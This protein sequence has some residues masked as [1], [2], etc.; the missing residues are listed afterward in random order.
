MRRLA[1]FAFVLLA[2]PL[3]AACD[4]KQETAAPQPQEP[5]SE[6]MARYCDMPVLDHSGPKGQIFVAGE[7]SPI[8]FA[9]ARDMV[10]FT[11][12]PEEPKDIVAIY[13]NDMGKADWDKPGAGTWTDARKAWFVIDS[14]RQG[15]MGGAEVVPFAD[16]ADAA[17]FAVQWGGR[18]VAFKDI[19][20]DYVLGADEAEGASKAYGPQGHAHET[21]SHEHG[22]R[23]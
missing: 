17:R 20:S 15:G 2:L 4:A 21:H 3:L 18:V 5:T 6:A 12:L 1:L 11:M 23:P 8:W 22:E 14:R 13:V 7:K 10:A 16:A 19:P 9:S